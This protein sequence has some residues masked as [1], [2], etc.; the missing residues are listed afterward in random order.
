MRCNRNCLIYNAWLSVVFWIYHRTLHSHSSKWNGQS[1]RRM[2]RKRE[3][4]RSELLWLC[5]YCLW[6]C[7]SVAI[8][9]ICLCVRWQ[10]CN[11]ILNKNHHHQLSSVHLSEWQ[12]DSVAAVCQKRFFPDDAQLY[13]V[14][15]ACVC[16]HFVNIISLTLFNG[17][18]HFWNQT[19]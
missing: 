17:W 11:K 3:H 5:I 10:L 14:L 7:V 18:N 13:F 2:N 12:T 1:E 16:C 8:R 15:D 9:W 6:F 4:I 19:K